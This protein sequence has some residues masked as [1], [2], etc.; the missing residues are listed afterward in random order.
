M[1]QTRRTVLGGL[2]AAGV[3]GL[4]AAC[5]TAGSEG[6][7]GGGDTGG[8]S[9]SGGSGSDKKSLTIGYIN[10]DEDVAVTHLWQKILQDKGYTVTTKQI[11]DAGPVYVGLSQGQLDL[12]LDAWLP[13]TH[14][15]YWAK[16]G[17][18]LTDIGTWYDSAPL[19]IAVPDYMKISSLEQLK[20][21]GSQVDHKIIGI[22]PGAGLTAAA[23]QMLKD[24]GLSDWTL[25]TSSTAAMLAALQNAVRDK[26]PIVVT[27]WRPHWAY[28]EYPI[29][30]LKDP[31]GSM[32]KPDSIRSIGTKNFESDYPE[33]TK[34]LKKFHMTDTQ[35]ASLETQVL[36]KNKS[37]P[38]TGVE[39]WLKENPKFVAG[40]G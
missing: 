4:T 31:K 2:M 14:K 18:Q 39:A 32:G 28:D 5:G 36:R 25:Q 13:A 40:L 27:L 3:A 22:E 10:W 35:L 33:L 29:K 19:T 38:Q 12:F 9:G 15:T 17:K 37:K 34:M 26:K 23:K 6:S 7:D 24:Y 30:D 16:Y 21:I 8:S 20:S 11:S 1:T